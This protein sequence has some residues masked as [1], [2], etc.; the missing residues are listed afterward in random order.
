MANTVV[1]ETVK[2]VEEVTEVAAEPVKETAKVFP[3]KGKT[4][5][6]IGGS[7][8]AVVVVYFG[9]K[10]LVEPRFRKK[11]NHKKV[12]KPAEEA[13]PVEAEPVETPEEASEVKKSGKKK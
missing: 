3:K 13:I 12:E 5:L 10:K 2:A 8:A 1:E 7:A 4:A 6:I 11:D 9:Y